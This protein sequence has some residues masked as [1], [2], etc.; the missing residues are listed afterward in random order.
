M[1][2][3]EPQITIGEV[4]VPGEEGAQLGEVVLA[5]DE[6]ELH[7]DGLALQEVEQGGHDGALGLLGDEAL[8]LFGELLGERH[9]LFKLIEDQEG[10]ALGA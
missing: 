4:A 9:Q 6:E 3:L 10:V 5:E 2:R 1:Q 8:S 7:G